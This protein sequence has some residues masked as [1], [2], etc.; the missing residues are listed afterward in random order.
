MRICEILKNQGRCN[1]VS[2]ATEC[3]M[4]KDYIGKIKQVRT[5]KNCSLDEAIEF[6]DSINWKYANFYEKTYPNMSF[7]RR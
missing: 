5:D 3:D 1:S 7:K 4:A 6:L 2:C